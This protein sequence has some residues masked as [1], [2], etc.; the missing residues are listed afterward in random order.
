MAA[1]IANDLAREIRLSN[2]EGAI[3]SKRMHSATGV[4]ATAGYALLRVL[5]VKMASDFMALFAVR[6]ARFLVRE[7]VIRRNL[8]AA[9]PDLDEPALDALMKKIVANFGRLLA[10]V[11]HIPTYVAGKQGTIVNASGSLEHTFQQSGQ[12]IYV[13]AHLGNWELVPIV[14][15]RR[16][17]M[18]VIYSLIGNRV[19]DNLLLSQRRKTGSIYV[20]KSKALRAS[21]KAMK[22]G[23]SVGLLVDQRVERGIEVTFFGRPTIVTDLPA[24]L[25]LKFNCPII[26]AE[27]VRAGPRRCQVM[28]HEPIWPGENRGEQAVRDLTQQMA[29]VVEDCIRKR[30]DEWCCDKRRWKKSDRTQSTA[31][32]ST[33]PRSA[34][35]STSVAQGINSSRAWVSPMHGNSAQQETCTP[36]AAYWFGRK[37]RKSTGRPNL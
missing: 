11:V 27:A 34:R 5:P 33:T 16:S 32:F 4:I 22:R 28:V 17:R 13:S 18:L 2:S 25:A 30:P 21:I 9:F 6:F 15:G 12:A 37:R 20:E 3:V 19:I 36:D 24:R 7:K 1:L 29:S 23:D 26:P 35:S 14:L 31:G 8:R 10:E